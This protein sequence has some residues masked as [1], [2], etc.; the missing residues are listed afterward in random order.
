MLSAQCNELRSIHGRTRTVMAW[1]FESLG[2]ML[3]EERGQLVKGDHI[4]TVIQIGV[5]GARDDD[6][7]LGLSGCRISGFTEVA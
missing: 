7:L 5:I 6:E 1:S 3:L 4:C 2:Q